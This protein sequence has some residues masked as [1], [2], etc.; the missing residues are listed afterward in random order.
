MTLGGTLGGDATRIGASSNLLAAGICGRSGSRVS[1]AGFARSGN[2][3]ALAQIAAA[4][5]YVFVL[6]LALRG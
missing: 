4:A 2:P 6:Y 5:V 1:F 3:I